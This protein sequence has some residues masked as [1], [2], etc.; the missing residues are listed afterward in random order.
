M[1]PVIGT[2]PRL[3]FL[4]RLRFIQT[5]LFHGSKKESR[6]KGKENE[7]GSVEN[8]FSDGLS[9]ATSGIESQIF[10]QPTI[11]ATFVILCQETTSNT[12]LLP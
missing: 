12:S 6:K 3:Y 4:E 8:A 2:N 1:G 7:N 10:V 9:R 11:T 5:L